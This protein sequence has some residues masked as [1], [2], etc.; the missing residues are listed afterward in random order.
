MKTLVSLVLSASL[1]GP[2]FAED[3]ASTMSVPSPLEAWQDEPTIILDG[4]DVDID[5]FKWVARLVIV[6]ATSPADPRFAE[7]MTLLS[8]RTQELI[9]RDVVVI[10]DTDDDTLSDLRRK[11]RPRDFMMVLIGK[12]GGVKLRKPFPYDVRELSRSID[13]MP[14][15][16]QEIRDRRGS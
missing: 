2:A 10:V 4:A 6:F 3:T 5:E 15:R 1:I 7:Q 12:D 9:D 14:L 8:E 16:Q 11:L 13:K